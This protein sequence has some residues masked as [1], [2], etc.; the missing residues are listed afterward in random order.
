M[1]RATAAAV[2]LLAAALP[3]IDARGDVSSTGISLRGPVAVRPNGTLALSGKAY[4]A[5]RLDFAVG[6]AKRCIALAVDRPGARPL[7]I[8]VEYAADRMLARDLLDAVRAARG[9]DAIHDR[10]SPGRSAV[11]ECGPIR[12]TVVLFNA[13]G[14]LSSDNL[15]LLQREF[16]SRQR[17][18]PAAAGD[19]AVRR[20]V[21]ERLASWSEAL[22]RIRAEAER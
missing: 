21:Q 15:R 16:R 13:N 7:E 1:S 11:L 18:L 12:V 4:G 20:E 10:F 17:A 14:W 22:Q 3:T 6:F 5:D 8:T 2:A 9:A 19:D